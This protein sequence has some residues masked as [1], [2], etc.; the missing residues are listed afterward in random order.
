[1]PSAAPQA[2]AQAS[3][4]ASAATDMNVPQMADDNTA[5][6]EALDSHI[7]SLPPEI[8]AEFEKSFMEYPKMPEVLGMLM[9]EA[10]EYFKTVQQGLLAREQ[11]SAPQGVPPNSPAQAQNA[12]PAGGTEQGLIPAQAQPQ[13][14]ATSAL[15]I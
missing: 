14:K 4:P 15:G 13:A 8:Q 7:D 9:P 12:A 10:Y 3:A 2:P 5:M 11:S 1:M 6:L